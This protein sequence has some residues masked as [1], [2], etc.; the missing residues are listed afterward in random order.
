MHQTNKSVSIALIEATFNELGECLAKAGD[1]AEI[2]IYGG[3]AMMLLFNTRDYTRDVDYVPLVGDMTLVTRIAQEIAAR[4]SLPADWLND[5]V[6][7][8]VSDQAKHDFFGD[9]PRDSKA[10]LRV[11]TAS[12][13]Y[14]FAMKCMAMR[15]VMES[16]D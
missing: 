7:V 13:E 1:T 6:K 4:N 3:T 12:P 11:F 14:L 8:F 5:S 10:G 9:Y 15:N 16:S 2:A